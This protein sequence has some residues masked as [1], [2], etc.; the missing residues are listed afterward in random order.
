MTISPEE[1][2]ATRSDWLT[3]A[4]DDLD[5]RDPLDAYNDALA[6]LEVQ[7]V[8]LNTLE[9]AHGITFDKSD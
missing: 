1:H 5:R 2:D 9:I 7:K 8:R 4:M 3:Q 6:L